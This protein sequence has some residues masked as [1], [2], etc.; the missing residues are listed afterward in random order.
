MSESAS[1][2]LEQPLV[3]IVMVSDYLPGSP[4]ALEELRRTL[5]A[6]G[7]QDFS[8]PVELLL[9]E[10]TDALQ[11]IPKELV[12]SLSFARVVPSDGRTAYD[13]KNSGALEARGDI[14][15]LI[16]SDCV[17]HRD[18]LAHL[19]RAFRENPETDVVSGRTL[20][21]AEGIM[22][23]IQALLDRSYVERRQAAPTQRI[24]NNNAA[25]RRGVMQEYPLQNVLGPFGSHLQSAAILRDGGKLRFEPGMCVYHA[26]GGWEMAK[27]ARVSQGFA[28]VRMRQVDSEASHPWMATLGFAAIPATFA[29]STIDSWRRSLLYHKHYGVTWYQLPVAFALAVA[30]HLIEIRG[31]VQALRKR[32]IDPGGYR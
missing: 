25:Y 1:P 13:L 20:Y 26:F 12:D 21:D 5:E 7:K 27:S 17:P 9:V 28:M 15:A 14:V 32:D 3:S 4:R 22:P 29:M 11:T 16:D 30:F 6:F 8:G 2:E 19:V 18:W 31:M 10:R 23:N 24:S